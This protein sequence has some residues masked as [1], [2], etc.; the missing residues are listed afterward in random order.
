MESD[1]VPPIQPEPKDQILMAVG[2][3]A[4][5]R[6]LSSVEHKNDFILTTQELRCAIARNPGLGRH[7][8]RSKSASNLYVWRHVEPGVS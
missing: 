2:Q 6:A 5:P 3:C 8:S 7:C 4:F 1:E